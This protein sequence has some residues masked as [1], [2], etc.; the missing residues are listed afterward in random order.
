[1]LCLSAGSIDQVQVGKHDAEAKESEA[2]MVMEDSAERRRG[3][4]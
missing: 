2:M 1:M 4:R 3:C